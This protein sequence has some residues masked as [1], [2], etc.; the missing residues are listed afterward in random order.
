MAAEPIPYRPTSITPVGRSA[1]LSEL[2]ANAR[3]R[4]ELDRV[5]AETVVRVAQTQATGVV[6][7][8]KVRELDALAREAMTGQAL[9]ARQRE[10][11][12]GADPLLYD[13]LR[14]FSDLARVGKGE[15][16]ADTVQAYCRESRGL[17]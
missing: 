10:V 3:L 7:S 15:V 11:L 13:E 17:R 6:Q 4:R 14:F 8:E 9:L 2:L 12:A 16:I 1:S 5:G